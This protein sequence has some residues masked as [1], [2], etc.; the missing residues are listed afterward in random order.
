[1]NNFLQT[2][3]DEIKSLKAQ[4][5]EAEGCADYDRCTVDSLVSDNKILAAR[6]AE[7]ERERDEWKVY[8]DSAIYAFVQI[9]E[10]GQWSPCGNYWQPSTDALNLI[11]GFRKSTPAISLAAIQAKAWNEAIKQAAEV[12]RE[13]YDEQEPWLE[14]SDIE[15]LYQ[16]T[17]EQGA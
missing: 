3:V 9:D 17:K 15:A 8:C 4:L 11:D 12:V 1:M 13:N 10:D 16:D 7:A 5:V 6:L 2:Y 14:V